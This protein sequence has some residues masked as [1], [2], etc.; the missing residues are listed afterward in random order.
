VDLFLTKTI[1]WKRAC[2]SDPQVLHTRYREQG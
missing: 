2:P 1:V